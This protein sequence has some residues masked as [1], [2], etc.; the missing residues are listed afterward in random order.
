MDKQLIVWRYLKGKR[1]S[2]ASTGSARSIFASTETVKPV[3]KPI[4]D[5]EEPTTGL[6]VKL[7]AAIV[8]SG[9]KKTPTKRRKK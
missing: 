2:R 3:T 7:T 5:L 6:T 4:P 1:S 8:K 9:K